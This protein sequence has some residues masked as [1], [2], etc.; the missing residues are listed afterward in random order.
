MRQAN[1]F[2]EMAGYHGDK[3]TYASVKPAQDT[4][5]R[6]EPL[7][8]VVAGLVDPKY[9]LPVMD[10]HVTLAW[11][12]NGN[13][14]PH[15]VHTQFPLLGSDL[16]YDAHGD[17]FAWFNKHLVMLLDSDALQDLHELIRDHLG[18]KYSFEQYNPHMTMAELDAP[19]DEEYA[20]E[21]LAVLNNTSIPRGLWFSGLRFED[22]SK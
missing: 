18:L 1:V 10:W 13:M 12:K 19:P 5:H 15:S 7:H 9:M 11:D 4:M 16:K 17:G 2:K 6:L 20:E 3:G 14:D 8:Q 21:V 22:C